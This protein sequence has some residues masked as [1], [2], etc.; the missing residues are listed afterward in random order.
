MGGI[1]AYPK[2]RGYLES[3]DRGDGMLEFADFNADSLWDL[4]RT[5]W[6]QRV[7]L[8]ER[9]IPAVERERQRAR[10]SAGHLAAWLGPERTGA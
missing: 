9:L 3:I 7:T 1:I 4:V 2:N 10:E 6:E 5:T 8:K